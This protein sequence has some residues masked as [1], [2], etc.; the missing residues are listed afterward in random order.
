LFCVRTNEER[1]KTFLSTFLSNLPLG[2]SS[3]TFLSQK[4]F[5]FTWLDRQGKGFLTKAE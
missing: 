1:L 2:S 4:Y 3:R 5:E